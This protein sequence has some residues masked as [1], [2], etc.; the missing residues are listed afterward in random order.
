M[1]PWEEPSISISLED[2][3]Y[4]MRAFNAEIDKTARIAAIAA[5][6]SASMRHHDKKK[7]RER[8]ALADW[9]TKVD[10][11]FFGKFGHRLTQSTRRSAI[12]GS[13]SSEDSDHTD[14]DKA[15][16]EPR[17]PFYDA[18]TGLPTTNP[19]GDDLSSREYRRCFS[20]ST[21][22]AGTVRP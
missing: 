12:H 20:C 16:I 5:A 2:D 7:R 10:S 8:K 21:Q 6:R 13:R 18:A 19:N 22:N 9:E 15:S 3:L 14:E 11:G 1:L 4:R 17:T